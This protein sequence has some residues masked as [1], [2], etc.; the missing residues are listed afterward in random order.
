[1]YVSM[2]VIDKK[3]NAPHDAERAAGFAHDGIQ[4]L[5]DPV[6]PGLLII[7][8]TNIICYSKYIHTYSTYSTYILFI[9]TIVK[10]CRLGQG[11]NNPFI[12]YLLFIFEKYCL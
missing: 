5:V 8:N 2:Y 7:N 1:M 4:L 3:E 12:P 6:L 11:S 10:Y 9:R